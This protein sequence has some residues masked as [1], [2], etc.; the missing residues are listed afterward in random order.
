MSECINENVVGQIIKR[1]D[2][3]GVNLG[4]SKLVNANPRYNLT[5]CQFHFCTFILNTR[6]KTISI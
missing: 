2:I 3:E 4:C 1:M 5:S 6:K